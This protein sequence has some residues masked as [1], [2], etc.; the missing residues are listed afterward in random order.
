MKFL[1]S[2]F[3]F[4]SHRHAHS[5]YPV[6]SCDNFLRKRQRVCDKESESWYH[7]IIFFLCEGDQLLYRRAQYVSTKW[8][9]LG[10]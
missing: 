3:F 6:C 1:R 10:E 4:P 2:S 5:S 7:I 8:H 9:V